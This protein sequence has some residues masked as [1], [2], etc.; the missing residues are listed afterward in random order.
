MV[1]LAGFRITA[2]VR[3]ISASVCLSGLGLLACGKILGVDF[4]VV[5]EQTANTGEAVGLTSAGG[6]HEINSAH[7][8]SW[9]TVSGTGNQPDGMAAGG[10]QGSG[11]SGVAEADANAGGV[12]G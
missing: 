1:R 9:S 7:S 5:A 3:P 4:D 2:Q 12:S 10:G 11:G 8:N 6:A